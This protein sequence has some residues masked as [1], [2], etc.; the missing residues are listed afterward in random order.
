MCKIVQSYKLCKGMIKNR[1][2]NDVYI[3]EAKSWGEKYEK[4]TQK[5]F[6]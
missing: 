3:I 6:V 2:K 4:N 5:F 1:A